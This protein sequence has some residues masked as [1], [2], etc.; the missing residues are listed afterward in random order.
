[1]TRNILDNV[2]LILAPDA[3]DQLRRLTLHETAAN[4]FT[5]VE[6]SDQFNAIMNQILHYYSIAENAAER[7]NVLSLV[8][9]IVPLSQLQENI[10]GNFKFLL[11][12]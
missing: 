7:I 6:G 1:M 8:A 12:I 5:R 10:P 11:K 3:S 2:F 4:A 9:D